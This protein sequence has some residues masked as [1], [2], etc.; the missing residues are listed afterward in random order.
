MHSAMAISE[1]EIKRWTVWLRAAGRPDTTIGLRTYH[2]RRAMQELDLDPW[3]VTAEDLMDFLGKHD[4]APETRRSYRASLR[5]FYTWAQATGRRVDNPA[6][7]IPSIALPRGVPRPTPET[8]YQKALLEADERVALMIQLA[9][10][11]GLRRGEIAGLRRDM[12]QEDLVGHSLVFPGKGGHVRRVPLLEDMARDLL[13][14]PPGWL[15]PSTAPGGGSL[16]PAHVGVLVSRALPEGWACHSLRHRFATV[17]YIRT[18]DLR[19]VQELLGHAKP[20][21]TARYTQVP[22][23]ALRRAVEAAAA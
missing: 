8:V 7:L 9:A 22:D 11:A 18:R 6:L 15:F 10:K 4:W 3:A 20:E 21:T 2:V 12:I 16:T 23:D 14:R 1:R 19:A 17:A 5:A 13:E